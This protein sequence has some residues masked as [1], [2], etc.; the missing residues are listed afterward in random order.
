MKRIKWGWVLICRTH[1][2]S[3]DNVHLFFSLFVSFSSS[4]VWAETEATQLFSDFGRRMSLHIYYF[5][6]LNALVFTGR[7]YCARRNIFSRC[8][9]KIIK[10]E[11]KTES[12]WK[13]ETAATTTTTPTADQQWQYSNTTIELEYARQKRVYCVFSCVSVFLSCF[14]SFLFHS[15]NAS[16]NYT[17]VCALR[18]VHVSVM[19]SEKKANK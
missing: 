9:F 18:R 15:V 1:T 4:F 8:L 19:W 16:K 13:K 7:R 10:R 2:K 5:Y 6:H 17:L 11:T 12:S 3:N 14:F